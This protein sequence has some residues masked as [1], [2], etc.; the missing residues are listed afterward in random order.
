MPQFPIVRNHAPWHKTLLIP[1]WMLQ[2]VFTIAVFALAVASLINNGNYRNYVYTGPYG[3]AG[4]Y[5]ES[6]SGA[7]TT[8]GIDTGL[9]IASIILIFVEAFKLA[10]RGLTPAIFLITNTIK[11][12]LFIALI[13]L[14][15][16]GIEKGYDRHRTGGI[17]AVVLDI[18][19]LLTI[20]LGLVYA[21][22]VLVNPRNVVLSNYG[23]VTQD[24]D[25]QNPVYSTNP[26][27][28]TN[29]LPNTV[30]EPEIT[31]HNLP[32]VQQQDPHSGPEYYRQQTTGIANPMP[33]YGSYYGTESFA[34]VDPRCH[35]LEQFGNETR[36][37]SGGGDFAAVYNSS[38]NQ[39]F[40]GRTRL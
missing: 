18:M 10:N 30:V 22:I 11:F 14:D 39:S 17:A 33:S 19:S 12:I 31:Y 27:P 7:S 3:S 20:L 9:S 34:S 38:H 5:A 8:L 6:N 28:M 37:S 40:P 24:A 36:V 13:G 4:S 26:V 15:G 23:V 16:A 32:S 1:L 25:K 21:T 2:L 35:E 29:T